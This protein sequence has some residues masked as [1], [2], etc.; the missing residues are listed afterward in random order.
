MLSRSTLLLMVL[1]CAAC[2][3]QGAQGPQPK[4]EFS[5]Q[6]AALFEDGVDLI[7]DPNQLEG[8]W[9]TDWDRQL[10]QRIAQS[11]LVA[12]GTV[13]TLRADVDLEQRTSYQVVVAVERTLE[14]KASGGD[15]NL[16]TRQGS[17]G[18]AGIDSHSTQL[19]N[20]KVVAFVK[21]AA[22]PDN[23]VIAHFHLSVSSQ[24]VLDRVN[25]FETRKQ[26]NQVKIIEHQQ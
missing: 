12:L 6:D 11:D 21:Y 5:V 13:T 25:A 1:S 15:L 18:Y 19:L 2:G 10:D 20:R 26:P 23:A 24:P 4:S 7:E 14:G 3:A 8:Q 17:G 22:G 16:V 9:R